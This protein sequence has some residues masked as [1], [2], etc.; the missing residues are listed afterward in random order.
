M[1]SAATFS[2]CCPACNGAKEDRSKTYCRACEDA[3]DTISAALGDDDLFGDY[4]NNDVKKNDNVKD[5]DDIPR[6]QPQQYKQDNLQ[7]SEA[8]LCTTKK[9]NADNARPDHNNNDNLVTPEELSQENSTRSITAAFLAAAQERSSAI[10][11]RRLDFS[12]EKTT[13]A[14]RSSSSSSRSR[15][16][17]SR[18]SRICPACNGKKEDDK[19]NKSICRDCEEAL[20]AS[21]QPGSSMLDDDD[22]ENNDD[23]AAL[24]GV[25]NA[26]SFVLNN[27]SP[28]LAG[29][30]TSFVSQNYST[31]AHPH[32]ERQGIAAVSHVVAAAGSNDDSLSGYNNN[33]ILTIQLRM[34]LY[35]GGPT[36]A[37]L[38][39]RFLTAQERG[40]V[41][42]IRS[43]P[44]EESTSSNHSSAA[45]NVS[46]SCP[47]V[48]T[49][50]DVKHSYSSYVP[51]SPL[52]IKPHSVET[53][54]LTGVSSSTTGTTSLTVQ[55]SNHNPKNAT[56]KSNRQDS[57][58]AAAA[59]AVSSVATMTTKCIDCGG[60]TGQSWMRRCNTCYTR[61]M[62]KLHS[63]SR[64]GAGAGTMH[65]CR[66]C[67]KQLD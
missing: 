54:I 41:L 52:T 29:T 2:S 37:D 7:Q 23:D 55:N 30:G 67:S 19:T 24:V 14:T 31:A 8:A 45:S 39:Q 5:H 13:S 9:R 18:S 50:V 33:F 48:I 10:R 34:T 26:K 42:E 27:Q 65:Q 36:T 16:R 22:K 3:L 20:A 66:M 53:S 11:R 49:G 17:S 40:Q 6:N 35:D 15:S 47:C 51:A 64:G 44:E 61:N 38:R 59:A 32:E 12:V 60:P 57:S 1:N 21:A 62:D 43:R 63:P 58:S 46:V 56:P 25:E 4:N 28:P